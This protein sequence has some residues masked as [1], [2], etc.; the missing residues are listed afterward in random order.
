MNKH[1]VRTISFGLLAAIGCQLD[2]LPEEDPAGPVL[3]C[4]GDGDCREGEVCLRDGEPQ[5][6]FCTWEPSPAASQAGLDALLLEI[7][8][9][10]DDPLYGGDGYITR[11]RDLMASVDGIELELPARVTITGQVSAG[12][13]QE[14][15][16]LPRARTTLP[17]RLRFTPR[18][19][20]M[21]LSTEYYEVQTRFDEQSEEYTFE[22]LL[23]AG[24]YD[25]YLRPLSELLPEN[26]TAVPQIYRNR[27]VE[28]GAG[29][30]FEPLP[31]ATLE[32]TIPWSDEAPLE[33]W[34][35]D[36]VHPA[37]GEVISNTTVLR[38]SQRAEGQTAVV[39]SLV[40]SQQDSADFVGPA[41]EWIRL[42]PPP[43]VTAATLLLER[44]GIAALELGAAT[45]P[46]V[47]SVGRPV[48]YQRWLWDTERRGVPARVEFVARRLDATPAGVI[49]SLRVIASVGSDGS[50][51]AKLPPGT[52]RVRQVPLAGEVGDTLPSTQTQVDVFAGADEQQGP[53]TV[54]PPGVSVSGRVVALAK[55]GNTAVANARVWA[56][57]TRYLD[58]DCQGSSPCV[59][60]RGTVERQ[61]RAEDPFRARPR[62]TP[63][64]Q[65]GQYTLVGLDCGPC[66]ESTGGYY[67]L[68]V[69]PDESTGLPWGF[70]PRSNYFENRSG[71]QIAVSAPLARRLILR[72]PLGEPVPGALVRAYALVDD[73]LA[74]TND[75]TLPICN[76]GPPPGESPCILGLLQVAEGRTNSNGEWLMLLPTDLQSSPM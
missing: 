37:T 70:L 59:I 35:L 53:V 39:A 44:G 28:L 32:L 7:A 31:P 27:R 46:E 30:Q 19:R 5:P 45:L 20:L 67:H 76:A 49:A 50:V 24:D 6:G 12:P 14:E 43:D 42:R 4:R 63:V 56:L 75:T 2:R 60:D 10:S 8:P 61:A 55:Q 74:I 48:T 57:P 36:M 9:P 40:Y 71:E 17:M 65:S 1:S 15:T 64:N 69:R 66:Q 34:K 23:P 33:G 52:Y 26:C 21:G 51:V 13:D 62:N 25:V 47:E 11:V 3:D 72:Q 41:E 18:E 54:V 68:T 16:C 38:G 29:L 58:S 73:R 22:G